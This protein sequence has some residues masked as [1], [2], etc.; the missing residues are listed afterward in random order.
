MCE[1]LSELEYN[2]NK[3]S[4][5]FHNYDHGVNVMHS[6]HMLYLRMQETKYKGLLDDITRIALIFGG[7]CHD[8]G[9][10]GRTNVFEMNKLS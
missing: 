10:T 7:L 1:F 6:C 3:R 2:Y 5:P 9:H 4:N 8:V